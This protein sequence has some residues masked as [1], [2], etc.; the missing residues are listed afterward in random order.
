MEIDEE[1]RSL[2]ER[3]KSVNLTNECA[4]VK[5]LK[6]PLIHKSSETDTFNDFQES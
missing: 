2:Q 3:Q 6:Q 5:L 4:E 1:I